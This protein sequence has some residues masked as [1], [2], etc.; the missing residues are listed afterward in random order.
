[1][2]TSSRKLPDDKQFPAA[3]GCTM[4]FARRLCLL[5]FG[6]GLGIGPAIPALQARPLPADSVGKSR[7][8]HRIGMEVRPG[9]LFPTSAFF[10]GDNAAGRPMRSVM[11]AHL[12][13]AFRFSPSSRPG[14]D[15]PTAYQGIG[16]A[17]TRFSNTA[18]LGNPVSVYVFQGARISRLAPR[19]SLS[20]EWN[21]GASFGWKKYNRLTNPHNDVVGSRI[22]AYL[23][24]GFFLNWQFTPQWELTVGVDGAHYS[25]G[26]TNYPNAG[27]NTVSARVG[28]ARTFGDPSGT[29]TARPDNGSRAGKRMGYDLVAYGSTRKRGFMWNDGYGQLIPGRFA[30]LGL[31][32]N[33]MYV[34]NKYFRTGLSLDA[35]YD[36]SANLHDYLAEEAAGQEMKFYRPPFREQFAVGL[37]ARVELNMP[38][39][40]VN[41]GIGRNL[42]YKGGDTRGFYQILAL[43]TFVSRRFFLH[44]GYQLKDFK[45]PNNLMLGVGVRMGR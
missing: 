9:Y 29:G 4:H 32:F 18:E 24:I 7:F 33:P 17:Y 35:Q 16:L 15:Y 2:T 20:Y 6:L 14:R 41:V 25:N 36:E 8:L 37:S 43:K 23:D 19:L 11:A 44:V 3:T 26:N 5:L 31:N 45:D 1:M 42:I 34:V 28:L 40:S 39:F 30:V 38:I 27:V 10:K 22:N 21:F 12:K 13:Y